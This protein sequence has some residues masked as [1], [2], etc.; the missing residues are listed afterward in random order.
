MAQKENDVIRQ[1]NSFYKDLKKWHDF[2]TQQ[3]LPDL[4]KKLRKGKP[5]PKD[6][7][8]RDTFIRMYL[9]VGSIIKL[10]H[11]K[12]FHVLAGVTRTIFEL[13]ID[14]H[15]LDKAKIDNGLE[16]FAT[17]I[18]AKKFSTAK[19]RKNWAEQNKFPF[20][21]KFPQ[22]A[23]CLQ[24]MEGNG[25]AKIIQQLWNSAKCP[26]HWSGLL[27]PDRVLKL[28]SDFIEEYIRFYDIGN[29]YVHPGPLDWQV[30]QDGKF[31]NIIAGFSY[32]GAVKMFCGCC[33]ICVNHFNLQ[34]DYTTLINE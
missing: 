30:L 11:F 27:I 29:W 6:S 2:A 14:M 4:D 1:V 17:F 3:I 15:L 18:A 34:L 5:T 7:A 13:Y 24:E 21:E 20:D 12:D 33:K 32:S 23:N 19:A 8:L 25:M 10:N 16:K 28:G 22:I 31:T 9:V 26:N